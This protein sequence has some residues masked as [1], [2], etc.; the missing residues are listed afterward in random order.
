MFVRGGFGRLN[1]QTMLRHG[2]K[3][4]KKEI[5]LFK[6]NCYQSPAGKGV[7]VREACFAPMRL[8]FDNGGYQVFRL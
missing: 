7:P 2:A 5:D 6:N 8:V 1:E 3:S 4:V